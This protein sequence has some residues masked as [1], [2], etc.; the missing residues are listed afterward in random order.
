[1]IVNKRGIAVSIGDYVQVENS[2]GQIY[3]GEIAKINVNLDI[4]RFIVKF[5][6]TDDE[7]AKIPIHRTLILRPD[8]VIKVLTDEE[9]Y[10]IDLVR[11]YV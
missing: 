5:L 3:Y 6:H 2:A 1:M 8:Q 11:D 4:G 7:S 10:F 9:V